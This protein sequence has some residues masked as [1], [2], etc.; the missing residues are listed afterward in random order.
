M[1]MKT[2][3]KQRKDIDRKRIYSGEQNQ[4]KKAPAIE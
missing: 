2:R 4:Y 1:Y 3:H